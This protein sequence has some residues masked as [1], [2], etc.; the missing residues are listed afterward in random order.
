MKVIKLTSGL[1]FLIALLFSTCSKQQSVKIN[2]G[3]TIVPNEQVLKELNSSIWIGSP[4][5]FGVSNNDEKYLNI[6]KTEFNTGQ[7][8]WY[9]GNGWENDSTFNF[10]KL[11]NI[12]NWMHDKG[13]SP[14][15]HMLAGQDLFMPKWLSQTTW[16]SVTL[17]NMLHIMIDT[18]M[19]T[20]DN[21]NK[22]DVWN[23]INEV[24]DDDG[25][26]RTNIVWNQ[27]GW[28][29]DS[30]ELTGDDKINERHP[31]FIRKAFN[32]CREKTDKKLELRDFNIE[33]NN[34][35]IDLNKKQKGFF[36]LVKHMLN[37]KTPIDAVGIQG[38]LQVGKNSWRLENNSMKSIVEK[39]RTLGLEVYI[40][41][42]DATI[43]KQ[44]WSESVAQRQKEDYY[45]YI[46]QAIDGGASRIYIWG[47]QDG[48]DK[49]WLTNEYPLPWDNNLEK[50][51]AYYGIKQALM[52]S[53]KR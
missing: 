26:Y 2:G 48:M 41:E 29:T 53:I 51:P 6:V 23:V 22:V 7:S 5:E 47:V 30:S 13:L 40:T 17:D 52:E 21:K 14:M 39:F 37:T 44:D 24:I 32:Y 50:K 10:T 27:M 15:V 45:N 42:L 34:P 3:G 25:C 43:E 9:A 20:N 35:T 16:D 33:C 38:H 18:I 46:K 1:Y 49:G 11:N 28:E 12:I 36:Q 8:L 4:I 31:V 19:E